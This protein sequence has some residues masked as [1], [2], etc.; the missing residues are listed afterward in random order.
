MVGSWR[1]TEEDMRPCSLNVSEGKLCNSMKTETWHT[2]RSCHFVAHHTKHTS[3]CVLRWAVNTTPCACLSPAASLLAPATVC[4]SASPV[5]VSVKCPPRAPSLAPRAACY[6][7]LFSTN[8]NTRIPHMLLLYLLIWASLVTCKICLDKAEGVCVFPRFVQILLDLSETVLL[9]C[10]L[11]G[12][13]G[14]KCSLL[15]CKS[16]WKVIKY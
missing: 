13:N 9:V 6:Y 8:T 5:F 16:S 7:A 14:T 1:D 3:L 12:N 11:K 4:P 15:N 2:L 10:A